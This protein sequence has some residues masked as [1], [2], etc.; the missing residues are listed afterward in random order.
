M[1]KATRKKEPG[2]LSKILLQKTLK[3]AASKFL[4]DPD[5]VLLLGVPGLKRHPF[6]AGI[7]R[8]AETK[9]VPRIAAID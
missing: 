1:L 2:V 6:P 8:V 4:L 7:L 5:G 9:F 3:I